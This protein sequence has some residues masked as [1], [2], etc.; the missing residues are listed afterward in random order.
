MTEPGCERISLADLADYAAGELPATAAAEL[1]AHLFTCA[2][3]GARAAECDGLVGTIPRVV[4]S[5]DVGG[6][7]TD[8]VLNQW[9]RDGVRV[10]T[11][12]L[13]PGDVVPCAV[14]DGD[15][16][17]ALRLRGEFGRASE[18]T[19]AR[20]VAGTAL[21]RV[22]MQVV[23]GARG[24]LVYAEP[25]EGIRRLPAADVE[26]VLT[27]REDGEERRVATYTLVHGGTLHR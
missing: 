21:D 22:S 16:V 23:P 26:I 9:S 11:F 24:E 1:E 17:M 14:W 27:A 5:G 19:L 20:R 7:V 8:D 25:A 13:S 6:F 12:T 2:A 4:A 10:R 18:V 15:D 3:C